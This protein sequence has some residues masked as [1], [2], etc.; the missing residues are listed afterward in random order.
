MNV[1]YRII[2]YLEAQT[3]NISGAGF[4]FL[5]SGSLPPQTIWWKSLNNSLCLAVF[6]SK[7]DCDEEVATA[8]G[9]LCLVRCFNNDSAPT[10]ETYNILSSNAFILVTNNTFKNPNGV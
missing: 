1:S 9:I 4:P 5:T 2:V 6:K 10:K 7:L 8:I 3:R